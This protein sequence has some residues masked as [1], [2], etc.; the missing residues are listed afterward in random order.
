MT[1]QL[2]TDEK[3]ILDHHRDMQENRKWGTLTLQYQDGEL[4]VVSKNETFKP[5]NG[6]GKK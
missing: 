5:K 3:L 4:V 6:N 2:A 1:A